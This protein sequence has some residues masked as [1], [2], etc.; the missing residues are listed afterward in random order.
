MEILRPVRTAFGATLLPLALALGAAPGAGQE[1]PFGIGS[2]DPDSLGSHRVVL[3]VRAPRQTSDP[4]DASEETDDLWRY[5]TDPQ[6]VLPR[7]ER[8]LKRTYFGG[9]AF[10]AIRPVVVTLVA[11]VAS[12]LGSPRRFVGTRTSW[13]E[14]ILD[15]WESR[16]AYRFDPENKWW[17]VSKR[18]LEAAARRADE[19]RRA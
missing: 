18:L 15:D 8:E 12:Y 5:W 4:P 14:P 7:L 2:W 6:V 1:V 9:E 3:Q 11:I 17:K 13:S 16:P 10:P 19:R